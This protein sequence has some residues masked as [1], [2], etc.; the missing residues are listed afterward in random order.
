MSLVSYWAH[1][2]LR[3]L[4]TG[5]WK[6]VVGCPSLEWGP[7]LRPFLGVNMFSPDIEEIRGSVIKGGQG[8][9]R[10]NCQVRTAAAFAET[11]GVNILHVKK[12]S[13]KLVSEKAQWKTE[14][15]R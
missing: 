7:T 6:M 13:F 10:C 15:R 3:H 8:E 5:R 9:R 14:K 11:D 4:L 1:E 2:D 12:T